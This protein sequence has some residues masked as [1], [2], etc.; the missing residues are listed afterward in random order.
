M[1]NLCDFSMKVKG[2]KEAVERVLSCIPDS[3]KPNGKTFAGYVSARKE[4]LKKRKDGLYE[5]EAVGHCNWSVEDA[6]RRSGAYSESNPSDTNLEEQSIDC[7][8]EVFS[9]ET[10]NDFGEHFVFKKGECVVEEYDSLETISVDEDG[11]EDRRHPRYIPD[12]DDYE[13]DMD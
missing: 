1:A 7:E 11:F 12:E 9:E 13:W 8:I 2:S 4:P 5:A 6:M 10:G 3:D